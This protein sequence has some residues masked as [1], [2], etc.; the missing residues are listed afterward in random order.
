MLKLLQTYYISKCLVRNLSV[1]PVYFNQIR[2]YSVL[3]VGENLIICRGK[4]LVE[5]I[6]E[7]AL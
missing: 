6:K 5:F 7:H 4:E 2:Q 3:S 1:N